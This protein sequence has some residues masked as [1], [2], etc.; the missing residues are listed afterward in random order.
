MKKGK[1]LEVEASH[2]YEEGDV[3][4]T[5]HQDFTLFPIGFSQVFYVEYRGRGFN[6]RVRA[7]NMPEWNDYHD[8]IA[9]YIRGESEECDTIIIEQESVGIFLAAIDEINRYYGCIEGLCGI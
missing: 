4:Y 1:V 2:Y 8:E 9:F 5:I 6:V 3:E 7:E